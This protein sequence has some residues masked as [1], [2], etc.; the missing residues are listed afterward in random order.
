MLQK[1]DHLEVT[2]AVKVVQEREAKLVL[3]SYFKIIINNDVSIEKNS[4]LGN[5]QIFETY[6][7]TILINGKFHNDTIKFDFL[8]KEKASV[9]P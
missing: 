2:N 4:I 6:S 8:Q 7:T 1:K 3:E 9:D 5:R